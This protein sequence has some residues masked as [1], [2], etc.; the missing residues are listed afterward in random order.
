MPVV[1][2]QITS[3]AAR[4]LPSRPRPAR[5]WS[6]MDIA[7]AGTPPYVAEPVFEQMEPGRPTGTL[8]HPS[9]R[10]ML[11]QARRVTSAENHT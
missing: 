5:S 11:V 10:A 4:S 6:A 1:V 2:L 9:V 7:V 3:A 8:V